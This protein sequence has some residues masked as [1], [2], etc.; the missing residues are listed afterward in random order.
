MAETTATAAAAAT[1]AATATVIEKKPATA[2]QM[3]IVDTIRAYW[4]KHGFPPTVREIATAHEVNVNAIQG[5]INRL[6]DKGILTRSGKAESGKASGRT[7]CLTD[8]SH[9]VGGRPITVQVSN[10]R[11]GNGVSV[12]I[13]DSMVVFMLVHEGKIVESGLYPVEQIEATCNAMKIADGPLVERFFSLGEK[14]LAKLL[15]S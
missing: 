1:A 3:K 10:C 14:R 13:L 6:I 7:L 2:A 4:L 12:A 15:R 9:A 11:A 8:G 5:Q